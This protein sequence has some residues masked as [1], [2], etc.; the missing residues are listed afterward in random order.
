MK[1][2][3]SGHARLGIFICNCL[4]QGIHLLVWS[5]ESEKRWEKSGAVWSA[6]EQESS[7]T[8]C[9][10]PRPTCSNFGRYLGGLQK[11]LPVSIP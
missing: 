9:Y 10:M 2:I 3:G 6:R 1:D 5:G 11:A 8:L 7:I 4:Y